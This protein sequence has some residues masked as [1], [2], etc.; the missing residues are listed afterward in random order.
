MYSIVGKEVK[1]T[2]FKV[3]LVSPAKQKFY[4]NFFNYAGKVMDQSKKTTYNPRYGTTGL[5]GDS[6]RIAKAM[7]GNHRL[8]S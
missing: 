8:T 2:T 3:G 7:S 1:M 5:Y 4:N 6:I